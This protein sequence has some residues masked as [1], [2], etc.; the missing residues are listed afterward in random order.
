VYVPT[1]GIGN[2]MIDGFSRRDILAIL[3]ASIAG[4]ENRLNKFKEPIEGT[5]RIDPIQE[6]YCDSGLLEGSFLHT[7]CQCCPSV[8]PK[9]KLQVQLAAKRESFLR[10][11][12]YFQW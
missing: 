3:F 2:C 10:L 5:F 7:I 11:G 12:W 9:F 1:R 6:D 4:S 8:D